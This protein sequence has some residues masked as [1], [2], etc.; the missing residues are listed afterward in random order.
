MIMEKVSSRSRLWGSVHRTHNPANP[1]DP[2]P[3][4]VMANG[5]L[6]SRAPGIAVQPHHGLEDL[7]GHVIAAALFQRVRILRTEPLRDFCPT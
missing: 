3:A 6:C 7:R 2:R 4:S 5:W 1:Q